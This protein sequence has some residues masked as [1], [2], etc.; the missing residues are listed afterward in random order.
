MVKRA[1]QILAILVEYTRECLAMLVKRHITSR[2]T[3]LIIRLDY[4]LNLAGSFL[5]EHIK[6]FINNLA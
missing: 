3:R 4:Y 2:N 5:Q 6:S 1:F